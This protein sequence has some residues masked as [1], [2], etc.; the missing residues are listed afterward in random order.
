MGFYRAR[1]G[2]DGGGGGLGGA[3]ARVGARTSWFLVGR[4]QSGYFWVRK[5][6]AKG[7]REGHRV[8]R[9]AMQRGE[10]PGVA[11]LARSLL[12]Y[13]ARRT[14]ERHRAESRPGLNRLALTSSLLLEQSQAPT[15]IMRRRRHL[16]QSAVPRARRPGAEMVTR[17]F[18][19]MPSWRAPCTRGSC[20]LA[21][22]LTRTGP[23]ALLLHLSS[24]GCSGT[25]ASRAAGC[26]VV[27]LPA[28]R[29]GPWVGRG[30]EGR[31]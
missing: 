16:E 8:S 17:C 20:T 13:I 30:G 21:R 3:E 11:E 1:D 14:C 19:L 9:A 31:F 12:L 22:A 25:S 6:F 23:A 28:C 29:P 7:V 2:E 15:L 10:K 27:S 5:T 26:S 18:T 24:S 4:H